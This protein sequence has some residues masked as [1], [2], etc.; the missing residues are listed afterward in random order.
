MPRLR[1]SVA[2]LQ[3][4]R[5]GFNPRSVYV[6]FV[7]DTVALWQVALSVPLFCPVSIILP[8]L[9][10]HSSVHL[11]STLHSPHHWHSNIKANA[12][13][14]FRHR[15]YKLYKNCTYKDQSNTTCFIM[16]SKRRH[17][18]AFTKPTSGRP[19][20]CWLVVY[21][22]ARVNGIPYA[23][24]NIWWGDTKLEIKK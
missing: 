22:N 11:P 5:L 23:F 6:E 24:S 18:S 3:P 15:L 16:Y 7:E 9:H 14:T 20:I 1:S 17:V 10:T 21:Y 13:Q 4:P 19:V 8:V 12:T 2:G